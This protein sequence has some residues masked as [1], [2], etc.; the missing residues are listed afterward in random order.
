VAVALRGNLSDFGIGEVFQLIGQQRKTGVLEV[1]GGSERIH[2]SFVEGCV[3]AAATVGLHED[4]ALGEMLVRTGLVTP[5]RM[6]ALQQQVEADE[7]SL[8]RLVLAE[9]GVSARHVESI[10]ELLTRETIFKLLRW[11]TGSFH[12]SAQKVSPRNEEA[13]R[14]PAEQILM[15]GLRMVDE[16]R[17]FDSDATRE[18]AV[19]RKAGSFDVYR[20]AVRGES[21]GQRAD[22][23]RLYELLDGKLSA[24]RAID[25]SRLGSFEGARLLTALRRAGAIEPVAAAELPRAPRASSAAAPARPLWRRAPAA[26]VPFLV[27]A[28][29]AWLAG[30]APAPAS[31]GLVPE[32]LAGARAAA[33]ALRLRNAA[34]AF[35]FAHGRWPT[36]AEELAAEGFGAETP[37]A[38]AEGSPYLVDVRG[39][40]P[41]W[42]SG[43]H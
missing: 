6:V 1:D 12:F 43:E 39:A 26:V 13:K 22:A 42:L 10:E 19:F 25:L 4:S 15:D 28:V 14:L 9:G 16:W 11:G 34:E 5:D 18:E 33:E 36:G 20:E 40:G 3:V 30:R 37:M 31:E 7:D 8:R 17:T 23:E 41:T 35:H 21:R 27:L 29:V 2:V 32:P 24:R 38:G